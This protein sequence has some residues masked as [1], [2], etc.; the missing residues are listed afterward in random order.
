MRAHRE[1]HT[2]K[3]CC[4][5]AT[6]LVGSGLAVAVAALAGLAWRHRYWSVAGRLHYSV[7]ALGALAFVWWLSYWNLLGYHL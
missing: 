4:P 2:R 1:R 7:L 6:A 3:H 5:A